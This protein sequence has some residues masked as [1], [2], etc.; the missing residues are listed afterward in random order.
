MNWLYTS[1]REKLTHLFSVLAK[2]SNTF[3]ESTILFIRPK[4][5]DLSNSNM[6]F[7]FN[8]SFS[9]SF[10]VT[11]S[12]GWHSWLIIGFAIALTFRSFTRIF[13]TSFTAAAIGLY[14]AV[15]LFWF[16]I[17]GVTLNWLHDTAWLKSLRLFF[18][19]FF[20]CDHLWLDTWTTSVTA[21][22]I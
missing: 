14:L 4:W 20:L 3:K 7:F 15:K 19:S 11:T 8:F 22:I 9:R 16:F 2:L 5:F 21:I 13:N 6:L 12:S 18:D 1:F 17:S 10:N